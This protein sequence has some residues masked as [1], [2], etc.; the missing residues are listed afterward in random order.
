MPR[1]DD[2]DDDRRRRPDDEY[3]E[4]DEEDDDD[5]PR[6]RR[7]AA[8][9][10]NGLAVA[11]L[12]LGILSLFCS[13]L[14]GIPAVVCGFLGLS[15]ANRV[16]AGKGMAI[17][18]MVL[19]VVGTVVSGVG[20]YFAV[21]GVKTGVAKVQGAASNNVST[22]NMKQ[23]G[24]A[25][26][27]SLDVNNQF[28]G[29][30]VRP[31]AGDPPAD[32]ARRL[33]WRVAALPYVEQGAL[34]NQFK[35]DEPWDGPANRPLSNAV[36]RTYA[37]PGDAAPQTRYRAFVGP[38]ALFD[39]DAKRVT[40]GSITDG[41]SNTIMAVEAADAVPWAQYNELPFSPA[42]PLPPL[43]R[44]GQA[45]FLVLMADGSVRNV[46]KSVSPQTLKAAI[47]RAGGEVGPAL[48]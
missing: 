27:N 14:T 36:V 17:A 46:Q 41:T 31:P 11:S 33:S 32:P 18:G 13:L 30:F 47:T 28:P 3:E 21:R 8:T 38:G 35:L 22:N 1:R 34:F 44:P 48:D 39:P 6:R 40:L 43:G 26:H 19:G 20:I 4:D 15:K 45:T 9:G 42:G 23:I 29:P 2:E 7:P 12:V 24:L 37:D 25:L 5:R 10:S 16:G